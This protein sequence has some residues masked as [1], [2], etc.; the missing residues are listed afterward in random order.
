MSWRSYRHRFVPW[1]LANW[2]SQA[3]RRTNQSVDERLVIASSIVDEV[4]TVCS[5]LEK[6]EKDSYHQCPNQCG[7]SGCRHRMSGHGKYGPG[8]A[9]YHRSRPV[10]QFCRG[11]AL[12]VRQSSLANAGRGVFLNDGIIRK[13]QLVAM[14]PGTVY[15]S[16]QPIFFQS[17]GNPFILRCV[18]GVLV[19]GSLSRLSTSIFRSC[20][21]RDRLGPDFLADSSWLTAY[22]INPLSIGQIVN[23][24]TKDNPANV[25]YE[26]ADLLVKFPPAHRRYIPNLNYEPL[27]CSPGEETDMTRVWVRIVGLV[28]SRDI[29]AGEEILSSYMTLVSE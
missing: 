1:L 23:N 25:S 3:V 17:L 4:S 2:T 16:F 29:S 20:W 12:A 14:Y 22:T 28:A 26:E 7:D 18:D 27:C 6:I 9:L 8:C 11:F 15:Q 10:I 13:G 21:H 19:D 24:G 5:M